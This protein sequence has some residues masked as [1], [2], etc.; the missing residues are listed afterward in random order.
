MFV[1]VDA[2]NLIRLIVFGVCCHEAVYVSQVV[3]G[4]L[5]RGLKFW[6]VVDFKVFVKMSFFVFGLMF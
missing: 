1:K 3:A 2:L 6:R 4:A 5:E